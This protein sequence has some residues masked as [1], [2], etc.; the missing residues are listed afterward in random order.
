MDP[1]EPA[2]SLKNDL[3]APIEVREGQGWR[4]LYP[5]RSLVLDGTEA[6]VRLRE[7][8]AAVGRC[9]ASA[10][11]LASKHFGLWSVEAVQ[12]DQEED[13]AV[14]FEAQRRRAGRE[15]QENEVEE[16][17]LR[18]SDHKLSDSALSAFLLIIAIVSTFFLT[19]F[20][21]SAASS[22]RA[23]DVTEAEAL[24]IGAIALVL[25]SCLSFSRVAFCNSV[26]TGCITRSI[27]LSICVGFFSFVAF[28]VHL[29]MLGFW[30]ISLIMWS[31]SL[32]CCGSLLWRGWRGRF[33]VGPSNVLPPIQNGERTWNEARQEVLQRTIV[34]EG[35][36]LEGPGRPCV[37]SWPGKY[38]GAWDA[39]VAS[40]RE[41]QVSAA[42]VFL[43]D[44]TADFG[45]HDPIPSQE[46]LSGQ[47]WCTPLYGE[48]KP[49]GCRWWSKWIA[50][51]EKAVAYRAELH[52]YFFEDAVGRGK[53]QS[54]GTAGVENLRRESLNDQRKEFMKSKQF[55]RH[56]RAGLEEVLKDP[57]HDGSSRYSREVNRLFLA[58]LPQG[59][60]EFLEVS[61]GLGNSQ[62][63]EVAWLE[64][65]GYPYTERDVPS[66][67]AAKGSEVNLAPPALPSA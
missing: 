1:D 28:T 36:V 14:S 5:G 64:R 17:V 61:E 30:Q 9:P 16:A 44:G 38:E 41:G 24:E 65:K 26:T 42:V 37:C 33:K 52:V 3:K 51:I 19:L 27:D 22:P 49:W 13:R 39:L 31:L 12:Q 34:F 59:D 60:R 50:N 2:P 15:R 67:L 20:A 4:V 54:F 53:V 35:S 43:P 57:R 29:A 32:F 45:K 40:S 6:M 55:E 46:G 11:L 56:L 25:W 58:W 21:A 66:W 23:E 18:K 62:K 63:A 8:P 10:G 48:E 7:F 47:C